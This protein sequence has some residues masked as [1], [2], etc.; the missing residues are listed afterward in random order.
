MELQPMVGIGSMYMTYQFA[1]EGSQRPILM[2][3]STLELEAALK[4]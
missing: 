4:A 3:I 2:P 1:L